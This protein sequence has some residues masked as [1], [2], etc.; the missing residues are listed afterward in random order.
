MGL[1]AWLRMLDY[2]LGDTKGLALALKGDGSEA[3]KWYS[4]LPVSSYLYG[5]IYLFL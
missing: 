3:G 4:P 2:L 5:S 1:F